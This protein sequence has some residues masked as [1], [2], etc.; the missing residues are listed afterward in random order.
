MLTLPYPPAAAHL[1][2]EAT[3]ETAAAGDVRIVGGEENG[4]LTLVTRG[5]TPRWL[6]ELRITGLA[7]YLGDAWARL[8]GAL[9]VELWRITERGTVREIPAEIAL[10]AATV[11]FRLEPGPY[12]QVTA[13]AGEPDEAAWQ[14]E[15]VDRTFPAAQS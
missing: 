7:P 5:L 15:I 1:P 11:G 2:K 8:L 6:P 4:G 9:A 12:L 3:D 10:G 13:P 14:R